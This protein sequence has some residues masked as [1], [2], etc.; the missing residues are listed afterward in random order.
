MSM[1]KSFLKN[2]SGATA[3]EYALLLVIVVAAAAAALSTVGTNLSSALTTGA[4]KI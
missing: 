4:G 3:A 2:E 1:I